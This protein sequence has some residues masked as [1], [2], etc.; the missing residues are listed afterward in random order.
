M[1][2]WVWF[3]ALL[4]I[5]TAWENFKTASVEWDHEEILTYPVCDRV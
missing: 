3:V 2:F 4:L 1:A 5:K